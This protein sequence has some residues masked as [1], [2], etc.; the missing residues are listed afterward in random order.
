[1][2]YCIH[3]GQPLDDG[4][5]FC[6]GC[7]QPVADMLIAAPQHKPSVAP[8]PLAAIGEQLRTVPWSM[9]VPLRSWWADGAWRRGWIGLFCLFAIAPFFILQA[10]ADDQDI[11]RIALGFAVYFAL[12]WL[13]VLYGLIRPPELNPWMLV[14]VVLFTV[15]AG[16]AIALFLEKHLAPDDTNMLRMILGVGIPEEFAK[17]LAVYLFVFRS[18]D[19]A[20]RNSP[21]LLIEIPHLAALLG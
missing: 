6:T 18:S 13:V 7:G 16:T 8:D 10:T 20:Y 2:R 17:A 5:A 4:A 3:C 11:R 1:M 19:A 14:R 9:L 15:A 12:L 21:V